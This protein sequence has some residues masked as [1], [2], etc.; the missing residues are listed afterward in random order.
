MMK[1]VQNVAASRKKELEY[2]IVALVDDA[3][4]KWIITAHGLITV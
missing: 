2:I 3:C 1:S 4:S